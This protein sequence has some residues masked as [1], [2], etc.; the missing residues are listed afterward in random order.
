M[1][2]I[3]GIRHHGA[4][5]AK[6][7]IKALKKMQPDLVLIEGPP[8]ANTLIPH[9]QNKELKPPVALLVYNPKNLQQASYFPFAE[10]SP[11]W[12]AMKY[13][14]NK[15]IKVEFFDLPQAMHYGLNIAEAAETQQALDFDATDETTNVEVIEDFSRDPLGYMGRL[16][17]Y[18]D[19]ERWW[20]CT[21]EQNDNDENIFPAVLDMMTALREELKKEEDKRTLQREAYMRKMMREA[22]KNGF[23]NVAIV[24]GAWHSPALADLKKH[25]LKIDTALL[26]GIKKQST[27]ATWVPWS[28]HR[29][30]MQSGYS[31]GIIAPAWYKLLFQNRK[32]VTIIFMTRVARLLRKEDL[33]GSSAS[34]IEAVRLAN[35]LAAMRG[36]TVAGMNE[37]KEAAIT[38]F[39]SG[40][41]AQLELIEKKLIIGDVMGKV[42]NDIP[43]VPLQ[44]DLEKC[45]KSARLTK[46]KNSLDSVDKRLDLRVPTQLQASHLLHR[47][48]ILNINWGKE[49]SGTI[50]SKGTFAENWRLIWKP[51]F[52]IK[53]IEA[54][55]WGNTVEKA[56][57]NFIQKTAA[58]SESLP[59]VTALVDAALKANL[60]LSIPKLVYYLQN[61]S[62]ITKDVTHLMEA[63]P[64]MVNVL[65]YGSTRKMNVQAVQEVVE[66][67]IPRICIGLSNACININE[68]A[69]QGMFQLIQSVNRAINIL[70][71]ATHLQTWLDTLEHIAL[72]TSI[73]GLLAGG[74]TR[75]LYDKG[76]WT[77][78]G[79]AEHMAYSL[80]TGQHAQDSA[81]WIQGFLSGSGLLLIHMPALWNIIDNWVNEMPFEKIENLLPLLRRTFSSFSPSERQKM[82]TMAQQGQI[83][84]TVT[85]DESLE[86]NNER[87]EQVLP[88]LKLLLGI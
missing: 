31:A 83:H 20:E 80:S 82:L 3:F 27:K 77:A 24:C 2:Q 73:N 4:G 45:I 86:F 43:V 7:L 70:N 78:E 5:S 18:E 56:A 55:M 36:L 62:A 12:Q 49:I 39:C 30:S 1:F 66:Q 64:A 41:E 75:I 16:A 58:E 28:Y 74:A 79:T 22:K 47:M 8:D 15:D 84:T 61:L 40:Y 53:I 85:E 81:H 72:N 13:A 87:A 26:K 60:A 34:I 6:S 33:E 38:I 48:N 11:E 68:E 42:P 21:F 54:G 59:Q 17:G 67:I 71:D 23:K 25:P 50:R 46:D 52:A 29:L 10:F 65:R 51:D 57:T 14:L 19:S 76:E 63:L 35:T 37:L 32:D 44:Q 69:T 9:V 88:T